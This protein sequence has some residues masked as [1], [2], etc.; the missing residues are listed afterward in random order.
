M[1][2]GKKISTHRDLTMRMIG[3]RNLMWMGKK[4][5]AQAFPRRTEI[6]NCW[7]R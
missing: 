3:F 4:N 2:F 7:I 6:T 1:L 5:P